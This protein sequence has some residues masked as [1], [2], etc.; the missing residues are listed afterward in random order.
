MN[1]FFHLS[2]QVDINLNVTSGLSLE[3]NE[4]HLVARS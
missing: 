1:F 3:S 2:A 4:C